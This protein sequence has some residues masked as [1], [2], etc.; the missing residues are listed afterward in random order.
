MLTDMKRSNSN[1]D[2]ETVEADSPEYPYGLS[3]SLDAESMEKLNMSEMPEIGEEMLVM[4]KV[5]VT[6]L[7]QHEMEGSD[8]DKHVSLQITEMGLKD[9]EKRA[10]DKMYG[11]N[12]EQST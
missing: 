8:K 10:A 9:E 7:S 3:I 2:K 5:R 1:T 12:N 11:G 6:S 4:A